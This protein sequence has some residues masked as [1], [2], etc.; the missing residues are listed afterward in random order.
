M[1]RIQLGMIK[2]WVG[3]GIAKNKFPYTSLAN[4]LLLL[5]LISDH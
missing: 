2:S 3:S 1:C 4:F 5:A